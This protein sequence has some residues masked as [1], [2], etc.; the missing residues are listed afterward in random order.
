MSG[1]AQAQGRPARDPSF[2]PAASPRV[3]DLIRWLAE[4]ENASPV[5]GYAVAVGL[6]ALAFGTRAV[7]GLIFEGLAPTFIIFFGATVAA[8]FL[9]GTRPA[10]LTI[11]VS[12]VAANILF[13]G[14]PGA[15]EFGTGDIV[16]AAVFLAQGVVIAL[17]GGRMRSLLRALVE[18]EAAIS[19]LYAG[20]VH[21]E[22]ELVRANQALQLLADAGVALNASLD[23]QRTM[24][25]LAS[26]VVPRLA[27]ACI[28][29]LAQDGRGQRVAQAY[30]SEELGEAIQ[31]FAAAGGAHELQKAIA[32]AV[33]GGNTWFVPTID[34]DTLRRLSGRPDPAGLAGDL[35]P[36]SIIV[37]PIES[38]D[39]VLGAMTFLRVG[40]SPP[41]DGSDVALA[42]QVGARAAIAIDHAR[43]YGEARRANDSKD[44]FLGFIS[45]ELRTPITVI[46]GGAHVLRARQGELPPDVAA[47]ILADIER[48]AERLSRML[49]NLLA[50]SRVEL[51]REVP[52]EPVL[53]QRLIPRL[54]AAL[55]P[56]NDCTLEARVDSNPPPVAG[57]PGYIE[58]VLRNLVQNAAKYSPPATPIEVVVAA[59]PTGGRVTVLDRGPGVPAEDLDR[60]FERFYRSPQTARLAPGAGLGLAV[61]RRLIEAMGGT[62]WAELRQEG[63]LAVTF[64]LP[65]FVG[66]GDADGP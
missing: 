6:L 58:H 65:A 18:R 48:E 52:V 53:L 7:L 22:A 10:L 24:T 35:A 13:V 50:L 15:F 33:R 8:A 66:E 62:I 9:A 42:R 5:R 17:F 43:L 25:A 23:R 31:A 46:H 36:R 57:D 34:N 37:V 26:L 14:E 16:V 54:C 59:E 47:S 32:D 41:Y 2:F 49:E 29:D 3:R 63:G 64:R 21:K 45:H 19:D 12:L 20:T 28:V 39:G 60:I 55:Q 4:E 11:F 40:D 1:E 27:D 44:E 61:C 56:G 51:D 30:A 38:R